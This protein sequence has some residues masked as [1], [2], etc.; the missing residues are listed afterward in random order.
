MFGF[1][2][3]HLLH[4]GVVEHAASGICCGEQ[5]DLV[6]REDVGRFCHEADSAEDDHVGIGLCGFLRQ[7]KGVATVVGNCLDLVRLIDMCKND[8][9][10]F[11]FQALDLS[12]QSVFVL[13]LLIAV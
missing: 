11:V 9:V 5:G 2:F 13:R 3:L 12:Y 10:S 6:G 4:D 8:S 7:G 1:G